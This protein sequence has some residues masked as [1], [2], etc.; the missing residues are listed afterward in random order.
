VAPR[1]VA[2]VDLDGVLADVR[3][4][5]HHVAARP[6]NWDAFFAGIG[7]DPV[8]AE[9]RAVVER[10]AAD[11]DIVY[12]TGR[13][14]RTREPT[15]DWLRRHRLP[16]GEL[17]MRPAGDRRPARVTKPQLLAR[18]ARDGRTVA[19]VVDDDPQVCAALQDAG[20]PVLVA[21]WM[22]PAAPLH[23]AQERLGR[24]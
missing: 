19:V 23:E 9:G 4:R 7:D 14:E 1:P 3:H 10:L 11:H 13:P 20:W 18:L 8:L 21:D 12:L 22:P 15:V 17:V 6:K 2:I 16:P 5:L 24:T